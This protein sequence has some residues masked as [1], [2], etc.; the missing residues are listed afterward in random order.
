MCNKYREV[1]D[2][3]REVIPLTHSEIVN[4]FLLFP[5]YMPHTRLISFFLVKVGAYCQNVEQAYIHMCAYRWSVSPQSG[6]GG[7]DDAK[8]LST[9]HH[10]VPGI[11]GPLTE[12][13]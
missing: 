9:W 11:A 2:F 10:P 3:S 7:Q 1:R 5:I 13:L 6:R 8:K 12:L 4:Y